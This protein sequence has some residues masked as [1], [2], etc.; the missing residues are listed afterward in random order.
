MTPRAVRSVSLIGPDV[1][2]TLACG[3]V[4]RRPLKDFPREVRDDL[5]R[6]LNRPAT[7]ERCEEPP[8]AA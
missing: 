8:E 3:H 4:Q 6:L 2:Q 1:V 7:C 5:R